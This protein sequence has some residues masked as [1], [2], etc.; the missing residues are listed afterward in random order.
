M[1]ERRS[2]NGLMIYNYIIWSLAIKKRFTIGIASPFLM[3]QDA[4]NV[5]GWVE[6]S[7]VAGCVWWD[8]SIFINF[9][10]AVWSETE[11]ERSENVSDIYEANYTVV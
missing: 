8:L 2:P 1:F 6:L 9:S 4:N 3:L 5:V 10:I 11:S 7:K